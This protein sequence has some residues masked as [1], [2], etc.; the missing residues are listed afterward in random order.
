MA[1][2]S[3]FSQVSFPPRAKALLSSLVL[4][5]SATTATPVL[6]AETEARDLK[7][8]AVLFQYYQQNYFETLVEYAWAEEQG[9]IANHGTYP[10]LLKGGVSLSYGLDEQAEDIFDRLAASNLS[11]PVRNRARF[12]LGKMQYLRGETD[13]AARNLNQIRG[14]LP[15]AVDAEYRY[16][17][18][19]VNVK[20][21]YLDAGE[22]V[23]ETIEQDSPY[24]PYFYFNLA[25]ALEG[26]ERTDDAIEALNRV[27]ALNDGSAELQRLAD[28]A[29]MALAY[30]YASHEDTLN[31]GLQLTSINT[32]G[33]Y[34]NRGLL[35]ASWMSINA[36]D[37]RQALAPLDVLTARSMALPEVQEAVLLRPHVYERMGLEGRAARGF[38]AADSRFRHALKELDDA[39]ETLDR[40]DVLELFVRNLNDVLDESDWFGRAPSVAVNRL[41]PFLVQLMSDHS[42]QSVLKD[43]RDLYAIRNNLERWKARRSDFD[44]ILAA[45][46]G[47]AGGASHGGRIRVIKRQLNE[48]L[49]EREQLATRLAQ[50]PQDKQSSI[51][52]LLEELTFEISKAETAIEALQA[53]NSLASS[54]HF[55]QQVTGRMADVDAELVRTESLITRLEDVM[56][57]LVR[58]ELDIHQHRLEQYQVEAQLAKVR[59][60]DRS[61]QTLEPEDEILD[62]SGAVQAQSQAAPQEGNRDE[63]I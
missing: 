53:G 39:R 62:E 50:L 17:A 3:A 52:W 10:E 12:F 13:T 33:A 45:R 44:T 5:L 2:R 4:T 20:L 21:G 8:G 23:A 27:I 61:L 47:G 57:T 60:L 11:E 22:A 31:A 56:V 15:A 32:T 59:I 49:S 19:L 63:K 14:E 35:G 41:S 43:L 24:A 58:T 55:E 38:I 42:F 9:G 30:V 37:F 51:R 34:S 1:A 29:R 36:G 54:A 18:A 28:R 25:I 6:A 26:Q 16:L 7:Y 48:A 46:A 40:S